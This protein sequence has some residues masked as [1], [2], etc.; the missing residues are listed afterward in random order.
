[1]NII[2]FKRILTSFA[3]EPSDVDI[4]LGKVIAQIR[5]EVIDISV[6]YS[7]DSEQKLLIT[8]NG[9]IYPARSWLLNR[10]ARLPQLADRILSNTN[11]FSEHNTNLPFVVPS[12]NLSS[13]LSTIEDSDNIVTENVVESLLLKASQ[14]LPGATSVLYLTSDAG[15]G[16]T[17]IINRAAKIQ[18]QRFKE[19]AVGSLIIPIPL[20]GRAFL[21]FD[22]A[23]IA[24]LVNKMRFNYLYY[25]AFIELVRMGAIVPA[26]DGYEE[27]LVEGSKN[28]AVS[29]LG[30]LAQSLESSGT[31]IVAARKA[32]FEYLS[33]KTQAKLF[34]AIGNRS[35]SFSRLAI[36]RWNKIQFLEYGQLRGVTDGEDIY[37]IVA[38]RLGYDHPLL[39]RAVLVRRLYDVATENSDRQALAEMLGN[40]PQ[41]Y[42]YTF[43]DA[44]IKREASE[45]WLLV[46]SKEAGEPL[47]EVSEHHDLL[48]RI[49][50]EMWESSSTSLRHDVIDVLVDIFSEGHKKNPRDTRQIKERLKQHSLLAIDS[51]KGQAL[52]FDHED[53]QSF[54]TGEALGRI[55]HSQSRSDSHTF[56]SV[57]LLSNVTI[58]QAIQY[59]SRNKIDFHEI[60]NKLVGIS[61]SET[62]FSY[63]KENCGALAI[64]LAECIS[65]KK[66]ELELD[67]L[68][69]PVD[70]LKG[71]SL[72]N[73]KFSR[74]HFQPTSLAGTNFDNIEFEDVTFERLEFNIEDKPFISCKFSE[75]QI[76]SIVLPNSDEHSFDP[77]QI[78]FW[79][80]GAGAIKSG[81]TTI[82]ESTSSQIDERF[83]I[84]EKLLRIFIR[85]TQVDEEIIRL[86]LGNI[87]AP[88]FFDGILHE[89]LDI[90][91]L[92]EV[93]W[94]GRGVQHRYK[95]TMQMLDVSETLEESHGSFDKF[96]KL[97][98]DQK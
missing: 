7:T 74:C 66:D 13:D 17:T 97:I 45:K 39:T 82:T 69:F 35:V 30:N 16:K 5:D 31:V 87:F 9:E 73:L 50:Q 21:T 92:E 20:T 49:A 70:A 33:F 61:R 95:L 78:D 71:R 26:F 84:L 51:S 64:R 86:R 44:I 19:K 36:S 3:D 10:V 28:E 4:R 85:S 8:E 89:L 68:F 48:S 52:A 40:S 47:L 77:D 58:E 80:L 63:C 57:A 93:P 38:G 62:D 27:M 76:S 90:K 15:E 88:R 67:A 42:F 1:M 22:D 55:L 14:P 53:F 23:V 2:E 59:I 29:A 60:L 37:S 6:S 91:L 72:K 79:I 96:C 25:D 24:S 54:Y 98:S 81:E 65:L 34:D 41:D 46:T 18:A 56:L 32:F 43:I 75:C 94:K 83:K 12:G 11:I